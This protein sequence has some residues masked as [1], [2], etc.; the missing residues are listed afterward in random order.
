MGDRP[1]HY[2]RLIEVDLPIK[3]VSEHARK[4]K[5]IRKGHLHNMHIWWATR[6]LASCRA[7]TLASL[8]PDPVDPH[9]PQGFIKTARQVLHPI[10][11]EGTDLTDLLT[12]RQ[13]LFDFIGLFAEWQSG[14]NHTYVTV[15]RDL[16]AA[17]EDDSPPVVLDPFA[18]AGSIPFEVLRMGAH[19]IGSDFN[20]VAV[21][22]NK[23]SQEYIPK[24]RVELVEEVEKWGTWLI[25]RVRKELLKYYAWDS[26]ESHPLA[27]IWA[28][29]V[30]CE[31]PQCGA[32]L[33]LL[34]MLWLSHKPGNLVALR[35]RGDKKNKR[36]HVEVFKPTSKDDVQ[37]PIC[38]RFAA[39]CPICNFTT[40]YERVRN[41]LRSRKGGTHDAQMMAVINRDTN[42]IR[43]FRVPNDQDRSL[44]DSAAE[45]L[46]ELATLENGLSLV[47][48]E[49][50]PDW[51]SGVFN[52]GLWNIST[53]GDLFT[54][55]QAL[56][57]STF[58]RVVRELQDELKTA[59]LD[60]TLSDAV[61]TCLALA[62]S[63]L[64]HYLS[65]V[66]IY[67]LDHMISAFIQGSGMAMRP[68]FAEANPLMSDLV[69]GF[70][71]SLKQLISVLKR[72]VSSPAHCGTVL[73]GSA[74]RIPLP[75]HSISCLVTDPPYYAAVPYADLSDFCYVWLKRM[76]QKIHRNLFLTELTPKN[77]ELIAY[78]VQPD[79]REMKDEK[80]F[81]KKM[82]EALTECRRVLKPEGIAVVIFAH[83][84]T[85]GWE[86]MLTALINAGWTVTA[87][88]PID[89]ERAARLRAKNSAVLASSVHLVCRPRANENGSLL[90]N[91]GEWGHVLRQLPKKIGDWLPRLEN[92]G[93][94][95]ADAIFAC[96]GPALE[97][98]SK[99]S[100]VERVSGERVDLKD[101]LVEV[102]AAVAREA[103]SMIFEDVD[104]T[105]LDD[106]A[107]ITAMWLWTMSFHDSADT[108][109]NTSTQSE[110]ISTNSSSST[111]FIMEYDAARKIAQSLGVRLEDLSSLI[112]LEGHKARLL[113]VSA[114]STYLFDG[115]V[116][117]N[118]PS[119][120]SHTPNKLILLDAIDTSGRDTVNDSFGLPP[121]T[122]SVLDRVHQSMLLFAAERGDLLRHLL[123]EEGVGRSVSFW[124]LAQALS[125]LYPVESEE[126]RWI[127]GVLVRKKSLGF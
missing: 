31:G 114:R 43:S 116:T 34:G 53:Y 11:G 91:V 115:D 69:G 49:P 124:K 127:D 118:P 93:I 89:T 29:T 39:T 88:W 1:H 63:N 66:S 14:V 68:D 73:L 110:E 24:Y 83:K 111:G 119:F 25:G 117:D 42:G 90:E 109:S 112:K 36:V 33:P 105:G 2:R 75:D 50:Y 99:Y 23:I 32:E 10:S 48:D 98:Y 17:V 59:R 18:G 46:K 81:E 16:V 13:T 19:S 8:L 61:C 94:V 38:R 6:P 15:A 56:A 55:R 126:K 64:S 107:R 35:Y 72:E 87:S 97:E 103:L 54:P 80:Y 123:V 86:A 71:Y 37:N 51:Y 102:W 9:C 21:L 27:F 22:I 44:A 77:E 57:M 67:A 92:E 52:P 113:S 28:R 82:Q 12:L 76:L 62:V 70:D 122:S 79:E 121:I 100:R 4:D 3:Q 120:H 96:L 101:Y 106:D 65:S 74:T 84:G 85:L 47:P 78:Y 40:S 104:T 95:G 30:R 26:A 20:P 58:V 5:N 108:E 45:R 125:A 60:S 7:V 41:Q